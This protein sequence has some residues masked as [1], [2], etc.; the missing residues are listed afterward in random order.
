M[1]GAL[2]VIAIDKLLEL[3]HLGVRHFLGQTGS[4]SHFQ[5][6]VHMFKKRAFF[7]FR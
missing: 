6:F 5:R 4:N 7:F 3:G 1:K 2:F